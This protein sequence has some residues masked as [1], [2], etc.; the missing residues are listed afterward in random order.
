MKNILTFLFG[1]LCLL[2]NAQT[3]DLMVNCTDP[4]DSEVCFAFSN[5][6]LG[7]PI[8]STIQVS[9]ATFDTSFVQGGVSKVVLDFDAS[10]GGDIDLELT[11]TLDSLLVDFIDYPAYVPL[12]IDS[13][14]IVTQPDCADSTGTITVT[15]NEGSQ[16]SLLG[17][18]SDAFTPGVGWIEVPSGTYFIVIQDEFCVDTT[19]IENVTV[20]DG[21]PEI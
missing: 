3:W 14:T 18:I 13:L 16:L 21:V 1:F 20:E 15:A 4:A 6:A 12:N 17:N 11:T 9:G 19:L 7:S 10:I 8:D 2:C 5:T